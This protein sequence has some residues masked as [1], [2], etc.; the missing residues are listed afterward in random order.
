[1]SINKNSIT[2]QVYNMLKE[3]ILKQEL[4][5][6]EKINS[7]KIAEDN[8]ISAMPVRDSLL[9]L[10]NE[11]LVINKPRVGF[12]VRD[13]TEEEID[14]IIEVRKMYETY[15]LDNHFNNID[16]NK[17]KNLKKKMDLIENDLNRKEFDK[18]DTELHYTF[19]KAS[20]N[21]FLIEKYDQIKDLVILFQ[22]IHLTRME[23]SHQEHQ[24]IVSN[25]LNG[26]KKKVIGLVKEHL[27]DVNEG[28][29]KSLGKNQ[30]K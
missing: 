27:L 14:N 10:T 11:G 18:I 24:K 6:G 25:I 7:R 8:E 5:I 9:K 30:N 13:F 22:H 3:K 12:Y 20:E 17:A 29:K 16:K 15:C 21:N 28:I 2:Y 1:M 23:K 4:K 19:I 26:N